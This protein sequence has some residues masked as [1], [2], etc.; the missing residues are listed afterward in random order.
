MSI[1]IGQFSKLVF[2]Y[3]Q[4]SRHNPKFVWKSSTLIYDLDYTVL[5]KSSFTVISL[6]H[7]IIRW[8]P[9]P[10]F[11]I[12]IQIQTNPI[13]RSHPDLPHFALAI[14]GETVSILKRIHDG[15]IED[16]RTRNTSTPTT[17]DQL[18]RGNSD[19]NAFFLGQFWV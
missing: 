15:D 3:R 1:L 6:F 13:P 14:E 11:L 4:I 7:L 12:Q 18:L 16:L 5:L 8:N 10:L 17:L 9:R 2:K 19:C